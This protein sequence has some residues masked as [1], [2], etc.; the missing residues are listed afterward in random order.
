MGCAGVGDRKKPVYPQQVK[1]SVVDPGKDREEQE[2]IEG[3]CN[4]VLRLTGA[5][6][7]LNEKCLP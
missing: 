1:R 5:G 2:R 4:L 3:R 6:G 7:G